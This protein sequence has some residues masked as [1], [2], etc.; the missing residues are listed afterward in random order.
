MKVIVQ[1]AIDASVVVDGSVVGSI[2]KG[3][4]LL[5]GFTHNDT[6]ASCQAMAKKIKN[7][8]IFEDEQGKMNLNIEQVEGKILSVSQFTLYADTTGGNRPSFV[9]AMKQDEAK[10]LYLYFNSCLRNLGLTVEEG[11]FQADMK[12]KFTNDGPVT[13]ILEN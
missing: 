1:R 10:R 12:V 11:I 4:M 8:R 6:E 3:Y 5:V 7:L 13:I 2:D 9:N